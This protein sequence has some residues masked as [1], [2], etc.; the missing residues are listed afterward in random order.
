M[1]KQNFHWLGCNSLQILVQATV[2]KFVYLPLWLPKSSIY[3]PRTLYLHWSLVKHA[4][5]GPI[6]SQKEQH[7]L[8]IN[9]A[10]LCWMEREKMHQEWCGGSEMERIKRH[11]WELRFLPW[12]NTLTL[13]SKW[14]QAAYV[15]PALSVWNSWFADYLNY[16]APAKSWRER[17]LC[18]SLSLKGQLMGCFNLR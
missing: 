3:L 11:V 4:S 17:R 12:I 1:H 15:P 14:R 18:N 13:C 16:L 9:N 7:L 10:L 6:L 8:H 2:V 5:H